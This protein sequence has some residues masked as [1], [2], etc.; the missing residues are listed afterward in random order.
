MTTIRLTPAQNRKLEGARKIFEARRGR[1]LSLGQV[2]AELADFIRRTAEEARPCSGDP[3]LDPK[4][5]W[6]FGRTDEKSVDK[7]VY[8]RR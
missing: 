3:L 4:I 8:G 7:L 2:V 5:G 1:R 6:H